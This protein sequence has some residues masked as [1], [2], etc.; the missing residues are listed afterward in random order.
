MIKCTLQLRVCPCALLSPHHRGALT[1]AFPG[2]LLYLE[3]GLYGTTTVSVND[4]N[5]RSF[6]WVRESLEVESHRSGYVAPHHR[7]SDQRFPIV[8]AISYDT[9]YHSAHCCCQHH[10]HHRMRQVRH[11]QSQPTRASQQ[12]KTTSRRSVIQLL[13][14]SGENPLVLVV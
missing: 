14:T 7:G 13:T 5:G 4:Q 3:A 11:G 8:F 2:S 6:V 12:Q 10:H 1:G 9:R